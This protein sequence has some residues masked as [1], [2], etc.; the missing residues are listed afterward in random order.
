LRQVGK[1]ARG[2]R[3]RDP[4]APEMRLLEFFE[5][6]ELCD[7]S[8][9]RSIVDDLKATNAGPAGLASGPQDT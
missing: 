9:F 5:H 3:I 1:P 8:A 7:I 4:N 2:E 6:E